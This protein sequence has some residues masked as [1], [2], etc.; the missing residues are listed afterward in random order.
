MVVLYLGVVD[1]A[2][3]D[4]QSKSLVFNSYQSLCMKI[5][6]Q[7]PNTKLVIIALRLS[8]YRI[9]K[10]ERIN[11]E[12]AR[13]AMMNRNIYFVNANKAV[14]NRQGIFR[15]DLYGWDRQHLNASG[16]SLWGGKIKQSI[17]SILNQD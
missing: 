4:D 6:H 8:P 1:F 9:L 15:K 16:Y 11:R 14:V 2:T 10:Y 7:L 12:L 5:I 17:L 13:M 3:A